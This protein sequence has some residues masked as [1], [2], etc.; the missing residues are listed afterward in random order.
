MGKRRVIDGTSEGLT[1]PAESNNIETQQ[2][3]SNASNALEGK[4]YRDKPAASVFATPS[5]IGSGY[6][7]TE[8]EDLF[9][10][11]VQLGSENEVNWRRD[12]GRNQ[13]GWEQAGRAIAGGI[14]KGVGTMIEMGGY[15]A[16]IPA[17]FEGIQ[18]LDDAQ[19]NSLIR[20]GKD[21][22]E[23]IDE[24]FPIYRTDPNATWD[25]SDSGWVWQQIQGLVDSGVGFGATGFG[26]GSMF[27]K[28]AA[29]LA[30]MTK[31]GLI[32][33]ELIATVGSGIAMNYAESRMMALDHYKTV[34][35]TAISAGRDKEEAEK[36]AAEE[37][38]DFT[39]QYR[40]ATMATDIFAMSTIF[41]GSAF[42]RG[43]A[44]VER[45]VK[46]QLGKVLLNAPAE[47]Y[48][49]IAGGF[50]QKENLRD[51]QLK[52]GIEPSDLT[53]SILGRAFNYAASEEGLLEGALGMLG[54]VGN[55]AVGI[56]V[57]KAAEAIT[58][59]DFSH[60]GKGTEARLAKEVSDIL[61]QSEDIKKLQFTAHT[62]GNKKEI[63]RLEALNFDLVAE[64]YFS[65]KRTTALENLLKQVADDT[66]ATDVQRDNARAM[67]NRLPEMEKRYVEMAT[68]HRGVDTAAM[69]KNALTR[70]YLEDGID[71]LN[72]ELSESRTKLQAEVVRDDGLFNDTVLERAMLKSQV[73]ELIKLS[74]KLESSHHATVSPGALTRINKVVDNAMNDLERLE[75][76]H[77]ESGDDI[78]GAV[79][80][81]SQ[82]YRDIMAN[83]KKKVEAKF[84]LNL[85]QD[86]YN[87]ATD[88]KYIKEANK[89]LLE[90]FETELES[91][92]D[93]DDV[94]DY[95]KVV[96]DSTLSKA[97]KEALIKK[98]YEKEAEITSEKGELG[99][100]IKLANKKHKKKAKRRANGTTV[101]NKGKNRPKIEYKPSEKTESVDGDKGKGPSEDQMTINEGDEVEDVD[102]DSHHDVRTDA[103][104][105]QGKDFDG[106]PPEDFQEVDSAYNAENADNELKRKSGFAW[107]DDSD[108][109]F[110]KSAQKNVDTRSSLPAYIADPNIEKEG[111]KIE[112]G[113]DDEFTP[114]LDKLNSDDPAVRN[115]Y[116]K[117]VPIR[118]NVLNEDGS[119]KMMDRE[120]KE[121]GAN[122]RKNLPVFSYVLKDN[123]SQATNF[124]MRKKI[125]DMLLQ[126]KKPTSEITEVGN[127]VIHFQDET[128]NPSS[129]FKNI[130]LHVHDGHGLVESKFDEVRQT[131]DEWGDRDGK[132]GRTYISSEDL[133][134]PN[135]EQY[136][137]LVKTN[138]ISKE[139]AQLLVDA[140]MLTEQYAM[141][142]TKFKEDNPLQGVE[143][144]T[145]ADIFDLFIYKT[146]KNDPLASAYP[147]S[148]ETANKKKGNA[149][150]K[151]TAMF[152][153]KLETVTLSDLAANPILLNQLVD[154]IQSMP[155]ST[156]LSFAN[157]TFKEAGL[158]RGF[159][160]G[161]KQV[162]SGDSYNQWMMDNGFIVTN[163][164][165]LKYGNTRANPW[166][167]YDQNNIGESGK[168]NG[169][170]GLLQGDQS[171]DSLA[172]KDRLA[173]L[174][175]ARD[176]LD[177]EIE[178]NTKNEGGLLNDSQIKKLNDD[179]RARY[180]EKV[181]SI[182][183]KHEPVKPSTKQTDPSESEIIEKFEKENAK[184]LEVLKS[185]YPGIE[186]KYTQ[187]EGVSM[188]IE[189]KSIF[190][191]N[192]KETA[193][194][195]AAAAEIKE[196][197]RKRKAEEE[198]AESEEKKV[199]VKEAKKKLDDVE[200]SVDTDT[201]TTKKEKVVIKS[202]TVNNGKVV[203]DKKADVVIREASP[204]VRGIIKTIRKRIKAILLSLTLGVAVVGGAVAVDNSAMLSYKLQDMGVMTADEAV[205]DVGEL[206]VIGE[207][208]EDTTTSD[209]TIAESRE[210][211]HSFFEVINTVRDK[212]DYYTN[213]S[214]K[215]S[216]FSYRSQ[217]NNSKGFVYIA[218]PNKKGRGGSAVSAGE[219]LTYNNV[220]GVGHFLIDSDIRG[221]NAS[222]PVRSVPG[223][224]YVPV[225]TFEG[226]SDGKG[227]IVNLKYV[228]RKNLTDSD[229]S[230][231]T[232]S[233]PTP[234]QQWSVD[235]ID[236]DNHV[237]SQGM[238]LAKGVNTKSGAPTGIMFKDQNTLSR[239]SGNSVVFIFEVDGSTV[240]RD[241]AG[242]F[243]QIRHEIKS[244]K[245]QYGKTD[246]EITIGRYDA[247]SFSAKPKANAD[248]T[249]STDRW[250]KYN[251]QD[252]GTALII[253][254]GQPS[255]QNQIIDGKIAGQANIK[256]ATVLIDASIAGKDTLYH[257]YA[258]HYIAAN[259]YSPI[260]QEA[261][262]KWGSEEALVQAIGEQAYD[263]DGEANKWWRKFVKWL[264][265]DLAKL[266]R[267]D[268]ERL[269][270]ILT[271]TFLENQ[272]VSKKTLLSTKPA[273]GTTIKY[274]PKGKDKQEYTVRDGKIYNTSDKEVFKNDSVDRNRIL[275]NASVRRG[276]S[277]VVENRGTKYVVDQNGEITSVKSG[278]VMKWGKNHKLRTEIAE[279]AKSQQAKSKKQQT[280]PKV[281]TSKEVKEI[282]RTLSTN[283]N[284]IEKV[285]S[286]DGSARYYVDKH[287]NRYVGMSS[288]VNPSD[289]KDEAGDWTGAAPIGS[290]VDTVLRGFFDGVAPEY[291]GDIKERMSE[292]AYDEL[293]RGAKAFKEKL[294]KKH[295]DNL[296]FIT[297]GL[298]VSDN[299]VT[300]SKAHVEQAVKSKVDRKLKYGIA[301]EFDMVIVNK[302]T[303]EAHL[304]DF[305][306]SRITGGKDA[307]SRLRKKYGGSSKA[308]GYAKQQNASRLIQQ[309]QTGIKFASMSLLIVATDYEKGGQETSTAEVQDTVLKLAA[310]DIDTVF[311][312]E[313]ADQLKRGERA[314]KQR[315][316]QSSVKEQIGELKK[317]YSFKQKGPGTAV[318]LDTSEFEIALDS[319]NGRISVMTFDW[320]GY[321]LDAVSYN[322]SPPKVRDLK[323]KDERLF[324]NKQEASNYIE[325]LLNKRVSQ[326]SDIELKIK[327]LEKLWAEEL[328]EIRISDAESGMSG[329]DGST[330][331][332]KDQRDSILLSLEPESFETEEEFDEAYQ[333]AINSDEYKELTAL[334]EEGDPRVNEVRKRYE[335]QIAEL[336]AQISEVKL[337]ASDRVVFGHPLIGK[338]FLKD[339][340][341]DR[342]LSLD[343][344]VKY[345]KKIEEGR[346]RI[347][348]NYPNEKL[349]KYI[350]QDS[351]GTEDWHQDYKELMQSVYE[352]AKKDAIASGKTLMLSNTALLENN[353]A[354]FDKVIS[355]PR[356][357]FLKRVKDTRPNAKYDIGEWKDG[358]DSAIS[359]VDKSKIV[360]TDGYLSDLLPAQQTSEAPKVKDATE[361]AIMADPMAA[362]GNI[363]NTSVIPTTSTANQNLKDAYKNRDNKTIFTEAGVNSEGDIDSL[364]AEVIADLTKKLCNK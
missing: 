41:K 303:G 51:A 339:S 84:A 162:S 193:K 69:W 295:G 189:G 1:T 183:K 175:D 356:Q 357:T 89:R 65:E 305:K 265:G 48:E 201:T 157:K 245:N 4:V 121:G 266:S 92:T 98:A 204:K 11:D 82:H 297:E 160:L 31:M 262:K 101:S 147:L 272:E 243:N 246:S 151:I 220:I 146:S 299:S 202:A 30:Q 80:K 198:K 221:N 122:V 257:E 133:V 317:L 102:V 300:A 362:L 345:L 36:L 104:Y 106:A 340:K 126:G 13:D 39:T 296:E 156:N 227:D 85:L 271:D 2:T 103:E 26:I 34:Y 284:G 23:S 264:L 14:G 12:L 116:I 72:A 40:L 185:K 203:S 63:K 74:K 87:Q 18:T 108:P 231:S 105:K 223:E 88:P 182:N 58:G 282:I 226:K 298:F 194:R 196:A 62:E 177:F 190:K 343:D 234:L 10:L 64:K 351:A 132:T 134:M 130:K 222:M 288:I 27:G 306:T 258:H 76:H 90:S 210:K 238:K 247:G 242:S 329:D 304:I 19:G 291:E 330:Q 360:N 128:Y 165:K 308:D 326:D 195:A 364:S 313:Y 363:F 341:D 321:E 137:L 93:F 114:D 124:E 111:A 79:D 115:E 81:S 252:G 127:G 56:G 176:Q 38:S 267:L 178:N 217:Y 213:S 281:E 53:T 149:K 285:E 50:F 274:A 21:I 52:L 29:S 236:W 97:D 316:Q 119:V 253:P 71:S 233:I 8:K 232:K 112:F 86:A 54:G 278:K 186:L 229:F 277:K 348:A 354:D 352:Q 141:K 5:G 342:F 68:K 22:K 286:A 228:K 159:K 32:T 163:V 315:T 244:I 3:P 166:V 256:A 230:D 180:A 361:T 140:I 240:I 28:G 67:L 312:K 43:G 259:R 91:L 215:D 344:D 6:S 212:N 109:A 37:T 205:V 150:T 332:L 171:D 249:L 70:D 328:A 349:D 302:Q 57:K 337:E 60:D 214:S 42:A 235:D 314:S 143:G 145:L 9:R 279:K 59:S 293:I 46:H 155:Y 161:G 120:V 184:A 129:E 152:N 269:K 135:G 301:T 350:I 322:E 346:N 99:K 24:S 138:T 107:V 49:E 168:V 77:K 113:W 207:T 7:K 237:R 197:D 270:N 66:N 125:V 280:K 153:G 294:I 174:K 216:L 307:V 325:S 336:K 276:D 263:Q 118:I 309:K 75:E 192:P 358:I 206:V 142:D 96:N 275:A 55:V 94:T 154:Y 44:E 181:D 327:E 318:F 17:M 78:K 164:A 211:D 187:E 261:I 35:D 310:E 287:G 347:I 338:S 273:E 292:E 191:Q 355:I 255:T 359:K 319:K 169:N 268:K 241:F 331:I 15:L 172:K 199:K 25:F 250:N 218:T 219:N 333:E 323:S 61:L 209:S 188:E 117:E 324:R 311:P 139:H 200:K 254:N 158:K 179:S 225:F 289:F 167:N 260:V 73:N 136:P 47:A 248:G 33:E 123:S 334:I 148:I 283:P 83:L 208:V 20:A 224:H 45:S 173:E 16:D 95:K 100:K 320:K 239:F 131:G 170:K 335:S 110:N 290:A 251:P 144:L 353:I